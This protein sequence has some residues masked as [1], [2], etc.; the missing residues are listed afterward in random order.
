MFILGRIDSF[1]C[2]LGPTGAAVL[3]HFQF[4]VDIDAALRLY[5]LQK[6]AALAHHLSHFLGEQYKILARSLQRISLIQLIRAALL[7]S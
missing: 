3:S 1:C 5:Q 4:G 7:R 2:P 6:S